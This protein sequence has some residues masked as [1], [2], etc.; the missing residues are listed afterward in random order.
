[1]SVYCEM[2]N[3]E[4]DS[5]RL[6]LMREELARAG[7]SAHV[8][9]AYDFS[10]DD[11]ATMERLC[12]KEGPWGV[13]HKQDM[14]CT[15]SHAA[16]WERFLASDAEFALVLEDDVFI[17]PELGAW[18][19]DM[20]WWPA[21]ADL[22]KI[23]RWRSRNNALRVLLDSKSTRVLGRRLSRLYSRHVGAA[24]YI[25]TRRAA[26][27]LLA[28]KPFDITVDNL[29]FNMNASKVA[30]R[31]NLYQ[32]VPA[33]VQQGNE[34]QTRVRRP[35]TR[36]RPTGWTLVRQKLKRGYYECAY[37]GRTILKALTGRARMARVP[38]AANSADTPS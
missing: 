38:F 5:D 12:R 35:A 23:E 1:M 13:F 14:A 6:S 29:L 30:A 34:P 20:S 7:L 26:E 33:M 19:A 36:V 37:P 17:S 8:F 28:E 18:L 27:L 22:V 3:L 24:G 21:D 25:L 15:I 32:V 2:I 16:V 31:L 9:P 4:R 10:K 11:P